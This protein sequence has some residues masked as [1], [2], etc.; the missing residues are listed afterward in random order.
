MSSDIHVHTTGILS[1]PE[2]ISSYDI[3]IF[4]EAHGESRNTLQ[5]ALERLLDKPI[6]GFTATPDR[7]DL[8][9]IKFDVQIEPATREELVEQGYL[10]ATELTSVVD[11]TGD[12]KVEVVD[13]LVNSFRDEFGQTL[14]FM[15]TKAQCALLAKQL[16][17]SGVKAVALVNQTPEQV[18]DILE[19]FS[20]GKVQMIVSCKRIG[21]GVDVKG[22]DTVVLAKYM[23]SSVDVNQYVG[24]AARPDSACRVWQLINPFHA[25]LSVP[26]V[27][28]PV[29][30][31][32]II[33]YN[34]ATATWESIEL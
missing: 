15:K 17:K 29:A 16:Q 2:D 11:Y 24:R 9:I 3:V 7:P 32:R 4:D 20:A 14:I 12:D 27:I 28:G 1:I 25:S 6:I 19:D 23:G 5:I 18:H 34:S 22:C 30:S 26:D 31:H 13:Q 33:G 8:K 10:A 21:V